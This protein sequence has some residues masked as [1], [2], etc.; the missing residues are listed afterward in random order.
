MLHATLI[1][2]VISLTA[3]LSVAAA[4]FADVQIASAFGNHMVLQ[5]ETR[6]PVWG[7]AEPE[8]GVTVEFA[9][10]R[11][12]TTA[13]LDG[14]WHLELDSVAASAKPAVFEVKGS[15]MAHAIRFEDVLVGEVW[16]CG[17]Q[18]NMERQLGLREGQKPIH[19]WEQE[20]A[21]ANHPTIRQLYVHQ[22]AAIGPQSHA[23]ASWSVCSPE[24]VA[25][26]SAVGYF[27]ARDLQASINVP[28]GIIHSSRGG[29]PAEAWMSAQALAQFPEFADSLAAI[30][31]S[32]AGQ[33]PATTRLAA[34][35]AAKLRSLRPS[36]M[37]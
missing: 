35:S 31:S 18:S 29:S 24:T 6:L 26:F 7:T 32:S 9:G 15:S 36:T 20:V 16:I 34:T 4:A 3:F 28:I 2:N 27:F 17:G 1:Q 11:K 30:G 8:E 21:A 12:H 22:R 33:R 19:N 37:V 5:C 14:R 25:E 23:E 10:Q 13:G